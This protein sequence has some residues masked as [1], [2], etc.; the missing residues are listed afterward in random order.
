MTA[1]LFHAKFC[2][3]NSIFRLFFGRHAFLTELLLF[4]SHVV[5]AFPKFS[6]VLR[7]LIKIYIMC[8]ISLAEPSASYVMFF[9]SPDAIGVVVPISPTFKVE[10][11]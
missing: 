2:L 9:G 6:L 11:K 1:I 10:K 3:S 8:L 7:Q 4:F 5:V